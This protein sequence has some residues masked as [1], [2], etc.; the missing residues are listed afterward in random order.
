M[1]NAKA[2]CLLLASCLLL[3]QLTLPCAQ[4]TRLG[5]AAA[6]LNRR[7]VLQQM[8]NQQGTAT[9]TNTTNDIPMAPLAVLQLSLFAANMSNLAYPGTLLASNTDVENSYTN[10]T[11]FQQ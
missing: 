5:P 9:V 7:S 4:A 2:P 10:Q 3:L 8:N 1:A 6:A 11:V